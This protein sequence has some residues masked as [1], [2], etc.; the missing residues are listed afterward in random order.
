MK[1]ILSKV[2]ICLLAIIC[3]AGCKKNKKEE[4]KEESKKI[5]IKDTIT[6]LNCNKTYT[7]ETINKSFINET[8]NQPYGTLI[9]YQTI[10]FKNE[11][12]GNAKNY[13]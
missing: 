5:E 6:T 2:F 8:T 9:E 3:L 11:K 7:N 10:I 12:S 13:I 4:P 1:K